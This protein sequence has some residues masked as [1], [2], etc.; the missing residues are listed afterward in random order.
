MK[1]LFLNKLIKN[2]YTFTSFLFYKILL[3]VK[4][5]WKVMGKGSKVEIVGINDTRIALLCD[6]TSYNIYI[7]HMCYIGYI[8]RIWFQSVSADRFWD[9][10]KRIWFLH[11]LYHTYYIKYLWSPHN[12]FTTSALSK[13]DTILITHNN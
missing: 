4:P 5:L 6:R 1:I 2:K 7:T 11:A 12:P 8:Q 10:G 9:F 13:N 3:G